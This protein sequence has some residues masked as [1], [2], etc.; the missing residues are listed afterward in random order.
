MGQLQQEWLIGGS[1]KW[2]GLSTGRVRSQKQVESRVWMG[3][4]MGEWWVYAHTTGWGTEL[5]VGQLQALYLSLSCIAH[6]L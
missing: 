3:L 6:H 4:L 2:V 1:N 5:V